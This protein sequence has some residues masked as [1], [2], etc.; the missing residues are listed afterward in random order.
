MHLTTFLERRQYHLIPVSSKTITLGDEVDVPTTVAD[1][2]GKELD[3]THQNVTTDLALFG[4]LPEKQSEQLYKQLQELPPHPGHF[5]NT[6]IEETVS[7]DTDLNLPL[8]ANLTAGIEGKRVSHYTF[9]N[10]KLQTMDEDLHGELRQHLY[11]FLQTNKKAFNEAFKEGWMNWIHLIE[12]LLYA[13]VKIT[14]DRSVE[15]KLNTNVEQLENVKGEVEAEHKREVTYQFTNDEFP[16]AMELVD[17]RT[18][19]C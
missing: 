15:G 9:D 4:S 12:Q 19:V 8:I 18:F 17:I 13:D 3:M 2:L 7:G 6:H 10:V 1:F 11:E 16:F 14:I 5:P